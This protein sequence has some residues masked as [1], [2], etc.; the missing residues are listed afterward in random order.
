MRSTV[1]HSSYLWYAG[2]CLLFKLLLKKAVSFLFS[3]FF[4]FF[5]NLSS[6]SFI[7]FSK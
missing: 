6:Y 7:T 2:G 3:F 1:Y 4:F 5:L